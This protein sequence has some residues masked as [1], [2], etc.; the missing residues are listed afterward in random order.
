MFS[1]PKCRK[2]KLYDINYSEFSEKLDGLAYFIK[3][4]NHCVTTKRNVTQN[5]MILKNES[6]IHNQSKLCAKFIEE[7]KRKGIVFF[8]YGN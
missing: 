1:A 5:C 3:M 7:L 8:I 4:S 2:K 6:R